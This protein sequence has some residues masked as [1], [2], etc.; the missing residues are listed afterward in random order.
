MQSFLTCTVVFSCK[1]E[2]KNT[3]S[4][5]G[6]TAMIFAHKGIPSALWQYYHKYLSAFKSRSV[7][8]T[9][10]ENSFSSPHIESPYRMFQRLHF[11]VS[12]CFI[13]SSMFLNFL[14]GDILLPFLLT[15]ATFIVKCVNDSICGRRVV[16]SAALRY[17]GHHSKS[18]QLK[19]NAWQDFFFFLTL[20]A[21][22]L[23]NGIWTQIPT[24]RSTFN[25]MHRQR[26]FYVLAIIR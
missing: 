17:R 22:P 8:L 24:F 7:F 11:L 13:Q 10:D 5:S 19:L 3:A 25:P 15:A 1:C 20:D 6:L 18:L 12:S 14:L 26:D 9:Q 21:P 2:M 16:C 23:V 4:Y